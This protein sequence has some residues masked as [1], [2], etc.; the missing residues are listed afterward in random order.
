MLKKLLE[1]I[2]IGSKKQSNSSELIK[3]IKTFSKRLYVLED[4]FFAKNE[5]KQG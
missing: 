1:K 2:F 5:N 4:E 3:K